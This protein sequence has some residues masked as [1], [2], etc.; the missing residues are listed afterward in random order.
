MKSE[1]P[2]QATARARRDV[3]EDPSFSRSIPSVHPSDVSVSRGA[4]IE[5]FFQRKEEELQ[6]KE[7][8]FGKVLEGKEF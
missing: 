4:P 7:S 6:K 1:V 5:R 2:R 3:E 8:R